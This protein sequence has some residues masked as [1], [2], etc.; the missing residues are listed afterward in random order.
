MLFGRLVQIEVEVAVL[1]QG[2]DQRAG[3]QL[4]DL[5]GEARCICSAR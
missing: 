2:F 3:D 4:V 1:V 5:V